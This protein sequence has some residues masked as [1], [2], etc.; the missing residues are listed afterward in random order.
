MSI[1]MKLAYWLDNRLARPEPPKPENTYKDCLAWKYYKIIKLR[2]LCRAD[3]AECVRNGQ[4]YSMIKL[5]QAERLLRMITEQLNNR[6]S[7]F[8]NFMN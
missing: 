2:E 1:E 8:N 4:P 6:P 7:Y 5:A 3:L